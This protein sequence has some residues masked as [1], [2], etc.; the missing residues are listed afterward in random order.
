MSPLSLVSGT[1]SPHLLSLTWYFWRVLARKLCSVSISL[2]ESDISWLNSDM[3]VGKNTPEGMLRLSQSMRSGGMS[4]CVPLV[5][6]LGSH[7]QGAAGTR[8]PVVGG[9]A[10]ICSAWARWEAVPAPCV[11][12]ATDAC[13]Y[14]AVG[15]MGIFYF[16]PHLCIYQL[17]FHRKREL[18][19]FHYWLINFHPCGLV[20]IYCILLF[21][22]LCSSI[23]IFL[24]ISSP[25]FLNFSTYILSVRL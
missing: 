19:P 8:Y 21:L 25:S 3:H 2:G 4:A 6:A 18:F 24:L 1:V 22:F 9:Y 14:C 10:S 23:F 13:S 11:S 5:M 12:A 20:D 16:W 7:G 17:S 15:R